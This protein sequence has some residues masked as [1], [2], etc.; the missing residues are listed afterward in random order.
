MHAQ[1][2]DVEER[3]FR[4]A[5]SYEQSGD[6]KNASRL[7]QELYEAYPAQQRY[8]D[9]VV[10]TLLALNQPASLLPLV[11]EQIARHAG[12]Q[13]LRMTELLALKGDILWKTGK[14]SQ[15]EE[16]WRQAALVA[17]AVSQA[18]VSIARTQAANRAFDLAIA[19][20]LQGRSRIGSPTLFSDDLS[21]LYGAVGNFVYGVQET[22]T[23]LRQTGNLN[24]AQGRIAAYLV[25][26]KGIEQTRDAL[27]KA[28]AAEPTNVLIQRLVGWLFREIKEYNRAFD[29]VQRLDNLVNAQGRELLAFADK[30]RQEGHY[31]AALRGYEKVIDK[32]RAN[33]YV[34]SALYGYARAMEGRLDEAQATGKTLREEELVGIIQRYRSVIHEYPNTAYAA[35]SHYRIARLFLDNLRQYDA[36]E[37]EF[38]KIFQ[39]YRAFPIAARASVDLGLLYIRRNQLAR[40]ADVLRSTLQLFGRMRTEADEAEFYIAELE[41]FAGNLD[42][43]ERR[44]MNLAANP[45]ADIAND[46]LE[47]LALIEYRRTPEG[48][49]VVQNF[50]KA[51]L[52]EKQER[53]DEA[54]EVY[55]RLAQSIKPHHPYAVIGEQALIRAGNLELRQKRY[56]AAYKLFSAVLEQFPDGTLGDVAMMHQADVLVLLGQ[57]EEA[58]QLYTALLG[59]FPR[60]TLLQQV[61]L[62]IRKLRGDA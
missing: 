53:Y 15:A 40:A 28:A 10:R 50:A 18:F 31:D 57:K 24:I 6:I 7:Y 41:Y 36:A 35:E 49:D 47:R 17:P 51:E 9:G 21:Q 8:F 30:A 32:G 19:T 26:Q 12:Q 52:A 61:R 16:V 38:T 42:S 37:Q 55:N 11:E 2:S 4:M 39:Q 1:Y 27:E 45:H 48:A 54:R 62:K 33:P 46:A 34:L 29:V 23:F 22:L 5:E 60:S 56:E 14:T 3:K 43:A 13:S 25:T 58:L 44:F 59:R 20:L